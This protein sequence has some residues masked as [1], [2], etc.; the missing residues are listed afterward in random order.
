MTNQTGKK[1][2]PIKQKE[3][4]VYTDRGRTERRQRNGI[5]CSDIYQTVGYGSF[6]FQFLLRTNIDYPKFEFP[7]EERRK[8]S[9]EDFKLKNYYFPWKLSDLFDLRILRT[10]FSSVLKA[11]ELKH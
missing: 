4:A 2:N 9:R 5:Q 7:F 1:K 11:F 10:V 3:F 8:R 6:S